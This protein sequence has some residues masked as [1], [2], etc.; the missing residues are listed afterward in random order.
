VSKRKDSRYMSGRAV[1]FACCSK[2]PGI[3]PEPR[4]F[5]GFQMRKNRLPGVRP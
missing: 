5:L 1:I 3:L 2:G 4:Y